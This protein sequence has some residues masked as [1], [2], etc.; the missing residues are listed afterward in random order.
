[1]NVTRNAEPSSHV[2]FDTVGSMFTAG[3]GVWHA[4]RKAT[5]AIAARVR[6]EISSPV[7]LGFLTVA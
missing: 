4:A 7:S 3:H 1:V 6:I 2:K 5:A